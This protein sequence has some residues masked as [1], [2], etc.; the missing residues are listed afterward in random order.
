MTKTKFV[1]QVALSCIAM[2]AAGWGQGPH[3]YLVLGTDQSIGGASLESAQLQQA[4]RVA[5]TLREVLQ[6]DSA[7]A[8]RAGYSLRIHRAFGKL[9]D[10]VDFDSGLPFFAGAYGVLFAADVKPSPTHFSSPDFGIYANTVLQCPMN[11]FS[12]PGAKQPWRLAGNL[13]V[14]QGGRRTG[15]IHGFAIYDGQCAIAGRGKQP[16]F[17]PLTHEQY[18]KLQIGSLNDQLMN[19]PSDASSIPAMRDAYQSAITQ[20]KEAIGQLQQQLANMSMA[21]RSAPVAVRTGYMEATLSSI[22]DREAVPLSVPNP[23][24]FDRSLPTSTVQSIA[25]YLPFLQAG[26]RQAGLPPGPPQDWQFLPA[27]EA[28]R[29]GL[30]WAALGA[31]LK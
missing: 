31:M 14:L 10:W 27:A 26:P 9:S 5:S 12:P 19:L 21:E 3:G 17:L 24:F 13:P 6:R 29:D 1:F 20:L 30:D 23:A 22:D 25:V 4:L 2:L 8:T 7:I 16:P 11:E 18:V 15:E 28:I